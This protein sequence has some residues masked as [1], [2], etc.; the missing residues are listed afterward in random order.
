MNVLLLFADSG[1]P[2]V[3][4]MLFIVS[5][6]WGAFKEPWAWER[7][8]GVGLMVFAIGLRVIFGV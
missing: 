6:L 5:T 2:P 1:I 4:V 8:S 3:S 7:G